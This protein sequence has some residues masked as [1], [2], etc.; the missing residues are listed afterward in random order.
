[1][2]VTIT[3]AARTPATINAH[4]ARGLTS[5]RY[6]DQL[7]R[8]GEHRRV[9]TWTAHD[10]LG[11]RRAIAKLDT[12]SAQLVLDDVDARAHNVRRD[13]A[14]HNEISVG[15][16]I[17]DR[18]RLLAHRRGDDFSA[19]LDHLVYTGGQLGRGPYLACRAR[20]SQSRLGHPR[21]LG[22]KIAPA[23]HGFLSM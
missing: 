10:R 20:S 6:S 5:H 22:R 14:P 7:A 9:G 4:T 19:A 2:P 15:A 1:M 8:G 11:P 18:R 12:A 3:A 23:L 21:L 17:V 16:D 13:R